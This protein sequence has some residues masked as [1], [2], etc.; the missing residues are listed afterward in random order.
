MGNTVLNIKDIENDVIFETFGNH[1]RFELKNALAIGKFCI[2]LQKFDDNNKQTAFI[3]C[4]M[5]I[6]EALVFA[7]EVLSGRYAG[8]AKQGGAP[9]TPVKVFESQG[10]SNRDGQII[11]RSLTLSKGRLWMFKGTECEGEKNVKTGGY[12]AKKG[13][14]ITNQVSV[15]LDDNALKAIAIMIQDEYIAYRTNQLRK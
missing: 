7:Q 13:A 1:S 9:N 10:G 11:Y 6:P 5:N 15:G 3:K 12:M 4:F 8:M 14:E 2:A